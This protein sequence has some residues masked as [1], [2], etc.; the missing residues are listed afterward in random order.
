MNQNPE[1]I[2]RDNIDKQLL[3]CGWVVQG[4]KQINLSAGNGVAIREYQ[5]ETGPADYILFVDKKPVGVIEA[6]RE[7]E[8]LKL[9]V[10]E[11]Q[12]AEYA[13]SKLKYLNNDPL[14]F[15][16]ESTG[17]LTRFTDY[18]DPKPRSRPVF[19]F[20]RPETF[21]QWLK[22]GKT[23]RARLHDTPIL[24][25]DGLRDCQVTAI[26]NIEKSFRD[27]RPKALI[28]MATGSGKTFTAIS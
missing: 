2:A 1:Q 15:V 23:L 27:N 17:E 21:Q 9:T 13:T 12:S 10:V 8:G 26:T 25:T 5:T 18:R 3:L 16:Y 24:E 11:E 20:H 28:Q 22:E 4:K 19:T 14:P 7:D 6:K